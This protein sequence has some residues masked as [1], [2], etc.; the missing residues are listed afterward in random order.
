MELS[1][2][3]ARTAHKGLLQKRLEEDICWIIPHV[4][5]GRPNWLRDWT[6]LSQGKLCN[7]ENLRNKKCLGISSAIVEF[8]FTITLS[9]SWMLSWQPELNERSVLFVVVLLC[10]SKT[11][12]SH[13]VFTL[14]CNPFELCHMTLYS[15]IVHITVF[16]KGIQHH[17][18]STPAT[19]INISDQKQKQSTILHWCENKSLFC[20]SSNFRPLPP[21]GRQ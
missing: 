19:C 12:T 8:L 3:H 10:Q 4:P 18:S 5:P 1:Q 11:T 9:Y 2:D 17:L 6:E 21:T 16:F 20:I 13:A 14:A 15:S 7:D